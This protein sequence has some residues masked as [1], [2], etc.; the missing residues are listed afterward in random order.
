MDT[1]YVGLLTVA[2][3]R[4]NLLSAKSGTCVRYFT[5]SEFL[6]DFLRSIAGSMGAGVERRFVS[7][8]QQK[9]QNFVIFYKVQMMMLSAL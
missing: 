3:N 6:P 7:L 8:S 2:V 5:L 9:K 4:Y 1:F